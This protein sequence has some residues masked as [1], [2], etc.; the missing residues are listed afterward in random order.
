MGKW[1]ESRRF[2][3]FGDGAQNHPAATG[4]NGRGESRGARTAHAGVQ[5]PVVSELKVGYS[6][7]VFDQGS[8]TNWTNHWQAR[9]GVDGG[10]PRIRSA[11][12]STPNQNWPRRRR[13]ERP[14]LAR[15]LHPLVRGARPARPAARAS[16]TCTGW[17]TAS[18]E[19]LAGGEIDARMVRAGQPRGSSSPT[20]SMRTRGTWPP[21]R[22][23]RA[24][25]AS[26]SATSPPRT[27]SRRFGVWV[28]DDWQ[29]S[30]RL[31]LNLG[32]RGGT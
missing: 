29:I 12:S 18:T 4:F 22:R 1:H 17:T 10:S 8:L 24:P 25:T 32:H 16:S 2:E 5:Q 14:Q 27:R 7:S 21:S 3:P 31:T 28:Q 30:D 6:S 26:A 23:S 13:A 20:R 11:A 19:L 9:N 15:R